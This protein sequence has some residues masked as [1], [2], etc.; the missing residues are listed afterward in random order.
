MSSRTN[1][2][3]SE[4]IAID[5][6]M[7]PTLRRPAWTRLNAFVERHFFAIAIAGALVSAVAM[8]HAMGGHISGD[9]R[10]YRDVSH[11][12][13]GGKLPYR[14][15][16]LEY[17]PY[18]IPIFLL[19]RLVADNEHYLAGFMVLSL[20]ADAA[21][22][23]FLIRAGRVSS[24]GIRALGPV[25]LYSFAV[26]FLQMLY[27]QRFDTWPAMLT[28]VLVMVFARRKFLTSGAL[29]AAGA[30]LKVYP[31]VLGPALMF[32]AIKQR[33][34]PRFLFGLAA[35][36]L[37]VGLLSVEL[38]WWRFAFFQANRGLQAES[39]YASVIWLGKLMSWWP[40]TW[41]RVIAWTEVLGPVASAVVPWARL[42]W[43]VSTLVSAGVAAARLW[44]DPNL[45][46]GDV[47][48]MF[49][50]PL[51]AFVI[52]NPVFSPQFMIWLL[53]LAALATLGRSLWAPLAILFC[54]M[55]TPLTHYHYGEGLELFSTGALVLRNVV[56]AGTWGGLLFEKRILLRQGYG[57]TRSGNR[58]SERDRKSDR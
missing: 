23:A 52:F 57:V 8:T 47:A 55:I 44:R 13:L 33:K 51:L 48:R 11:D 25:A 1:F 7:L 50:L 36:I 41:G 22:K 56:L 17:P 31:I 3:V 54:A 34:L 27:L 9:V 39:L 29:L 58:K 14:D 15:R 28:I 38:P 10:L 2:K 35:G 40:A 19:P 6:R 30:F 24:Y 32:S 45:S 5:D 18:C 12:L 26:P 46:L 53:A 4:E 16:T 49:L 20:L 43:I 37:P 21:L 42:I